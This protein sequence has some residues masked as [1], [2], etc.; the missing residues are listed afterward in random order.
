MKFIT[1]FSMFLAFVGFVICSIV[2]SMSLIGP[3]SQA[4]NADQFKVFAMIWIFCGTT[5]KP[6]G[7]PGS[8]L[9]VPVWPRMTSPRSVSL[10][11]VAEMMT[12]QPSW[13]AKPWLVPG[14]RSTSAGTPWSDQDA[15]RHHRS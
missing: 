5:W 1:K 3:E 7:S 9:I 8:N 15:S 14:R 12:W 6:F 4:L 13:S 2:L 10:A 11:M